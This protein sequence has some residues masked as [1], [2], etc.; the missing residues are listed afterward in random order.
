MPFAG[1]ALRVQGI[2]LRKIKAGIL[3]LG[4]V[5]RENQKLVVLFSVAYCQAHFIFTAPGFDPSGIGEMSGGNVDRDQLSC[6][7]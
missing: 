3:T 4:R 1:Y 6:D 5:V 7:R 2:N